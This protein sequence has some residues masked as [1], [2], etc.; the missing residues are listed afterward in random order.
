MLFVLSIADQAVGGVDG[1]NVADFLF[2]RGLRILAFPG[3][4]LLKGMCV[5][6]D[7]MFDWG[8]V[9]PVQFIV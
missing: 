6:L 3:F 1:S 4:L 2:M 7:L 5:V 9:M 8:A